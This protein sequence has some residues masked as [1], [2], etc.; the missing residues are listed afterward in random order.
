MIID[1]IRDIKNTSKHFLR[2][3]SYLACDFLCLF[4]MFPMALKVTT[5]IDDA[6]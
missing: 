4:L 6:E 2:L 5:E 1:K 3:Y